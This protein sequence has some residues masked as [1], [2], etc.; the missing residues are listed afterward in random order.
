MPADTSDWDAFCKKLNALDASKHQFYR[1]AAHRM[2]GELLADVIPNTPT[3]VYPSSSG[4]KGGTLKRGWVAKSHK[5]AAR[6]PGTPTKAEQDEYANKLPVRH[7]GMTYETTVTN[8]VEYASYVEF[9]HRTRRRKSL[10]DAH[11]NAQKRRGW[12][13]GQ[14]MMQDAAER[15]KSREYKIL[16]SLLDEWIKREVFDDGK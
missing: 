6:N 15:V 11:G 1:N 2:A 12:V 14:Y 8:P 16:N 9:G 5:A 10:V 7:K 3:G 4:K 13:P